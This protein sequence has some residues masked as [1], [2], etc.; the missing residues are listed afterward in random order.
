MRTL[1]LWDIDRTLLYL[2]R[3]GGSWFLQ[4]LA[5]ITGHT[6]APSAALSFAGRTDRWIA[7][8]LLLEVGVEPS[9]DMITRLYDAATTH[10]SADRQ[11]IAEHGVVLPGVSEVLG[12]LA[13]RP[14][15]V[16]TLVTGNLKPIA[17]FKVEAFGLDKYLDLEIGSYGGTSEDR[18][19]LVAEAITGAGRRYGEQ[20]RVVVVGDTPHD[21]QGALAQQ[22]RAVGVATGGFD[23]DALHASGAHA[24]LPDLA[25]T[26]HALATILD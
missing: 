21:V 26:A 12:E 16:Q 24:V 1:V 9:E 15:V 2:P 25:D 3:V 5:D 18:A 11:R 17:G 4:A 23:A 8:Q 10:A 20:F 19:V 7:R 13:G 22:A 14:D 6:P